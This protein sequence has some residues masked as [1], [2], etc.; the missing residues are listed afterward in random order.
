MLR[1]IPFIPLFILQLCIEALIMLRSTRFDGM[2][3][4][5]YNKKYFMAPTQKDAE[6]QAIIARTELLVVVPV[7][8][9]GLKQISGMKSALL[10]ELSSLSIFDD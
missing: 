5:R 7:S 8:A 6:I 3:N 1:I 2:V 4:T 9:V 10:G